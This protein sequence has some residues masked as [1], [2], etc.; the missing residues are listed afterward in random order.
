MNINEFNKFE[1][2]LNKYQLIYGFLIISISIFLII[3]LLLGKN[4]ASY[5]YQGII[6]KNNLLITNLS[7]NDLNKLVEF[8][9]VLIEGQEV[10]LKTTDILEENGKYSLNL[11]GNLG[12]F[13]SKKSLKVKFIIREESLFQFILNNLKGGV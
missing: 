5:E 10:D 1:C 11:K 4:T 12:K 13:A 9:K 2:N 7:L 6:E 8:Q 3:S